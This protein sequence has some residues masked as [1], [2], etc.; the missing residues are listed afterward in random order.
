M[1]IKKIISSQRS[2]MRDEEKF[3]GY[4]QRRHGQMYATDTTVR[5]GEIMSQK[6]VGVPFLKLEM[7]R[8]RE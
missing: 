5:N 3:A 1:Y 2:F 8:T 6:E 7:P 4:F